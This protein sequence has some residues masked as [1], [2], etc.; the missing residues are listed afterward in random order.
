MSASYPIVNLRLF[1]VIIGFT[2]SSVLP[3][4]G[5][6]QQSV[7]ATGLVFEDPLDVEKF[8]VAPTYRAFL[9]EKAD[10]SA[11]MPAVGNQ[12]KQGSCVG[13]AVGYAAR[14]YY[15][16]ASD[17]LTLTDPDNLVSP[18]FLYDSVRSGN[19]GGGSVISKSLN[20]LKKGSL[21][22]KEYPYDENKCRNPNQVVSEKLER[23]KIRTWLK[24]EHK[25]LDQVRG[26]LAQGHPVIIGANLNPGFHNLRRGQVW[27]AGPP[28]ADEKRSGHAFTIVGYDDRRK[29]FKFI[30]S[31]GSE[32]GNRGYGQMDYDTFKNRVRHAYHIV[33]TNPPKKSHVA[34]VL[35]TPDPIIKPEPGP[36]PQI[37][38]ALP[39]F[40]CS[41]L[42]FKNDKNQAT[43]FGFVGTSKDF[44][45]LKQEVG[46]HAKLDVSVRPW[47]QCEAL[48]I[49]GTKDTARATRLTLEK[50]EFRADDEL[51]IKVE[52]P[53]FSTHLHLAYFQA[54]G[55]VVHLSQSALDNLETVGPRSKLVYGDG[56][57]GRP[58]FV[59]QEPFGNEMV[60]AI[61]T[62][63]P[64]FS[65]KRPEIETERE[66]LTAL[67]RATIDLQQNEGLSRFYSADYFPLQTKPGKD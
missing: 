54:D 11:R 65:S 13:W 64:L 47:P 43:V 30:N 17:G 61:T 55:S 60:L 63:S 39:E 25:N 40:E 6:Q 53:N 49:I 62:R 37:K 48:L 59:V 58:R 44:E 36:K 56:N 14:S 66:F 51:N 41:S 19:C 67:R 50:Q 35:P 21:S 24:L 27:S 46:T 16:K 33:P 22:V 42:A 12:G 34:V 45:T 31:W 4:Q 3:S 18:A 10:L 8:P 29:H 7:Y 52:T 5:Q 32:W 20:F 15:S 26:A 1:T 38:L 57:E 23:F 9:P 2:L 28:T